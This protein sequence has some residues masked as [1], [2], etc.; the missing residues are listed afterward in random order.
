MST[1]LS[2]GGFRIQDGKGFQITFENGWTVSVQFG[3]YNYCN[4]YVQFG[5]ENADMPYALANQEAGSRGSANAECALINPAGEL[6]HR[7][8]WGDSV[9]S[10][11]TP[12]EVL[13]LLNQAAGMSADTGNSK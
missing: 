5:S 8:E 6:V 7:E 9:S 3:V 11:S 2:K 1:D 13:E 12:A 4:N 10:R